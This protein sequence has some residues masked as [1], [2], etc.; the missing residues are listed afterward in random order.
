[1]K[2]RAVFMH[3]VD[4]AVRIGTRIPAIHGNFI[5]EIFFRSG[6]VPLGDHDVS[7]HALRARRSGRQFAVLDAIGPVGIFRE[8]ALAAHARRNGV[9]HAA[10]L[11][12][13][14]AAV[15]CGVGGVKCAERWGNSARGLVAQLVAGFA[16][17]GLYVFNP[18]ALILDALGDAVSFVA[19][20]GEIALRRNVQQGIPVGGGII[21]R[22]FVRIR[23]E[24]GGQIRA[25]FPASAF[26]LGE[27]TRP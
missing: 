21:L 5:V 16:A 20:A 8:E 13:L 26:T 11:R 25:F 4:Q 24:D 18:L 9:H 15:P 3:A 1:M 2:I 22:R 12:G 17:V 27:S 10:D 6:P 23:R 14:D 7:L 19:R